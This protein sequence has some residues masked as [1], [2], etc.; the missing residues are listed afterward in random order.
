M[1]GRWPGLWGHLWVSAALQASQKT[2]HCAAEFLKRTKLVQPLKKQPPMNVDE[3]LL[4]QDKS[5]A[6]EHLRRALPYVESPQEPLREAGVRFMGMAGRCLRRQQQGLR[7]ICTA[8]Q[9]R[10]Q[11]AGASCCDQANQVDFPP[12]AQEGSS[13]PVS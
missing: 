12:R 5:Q 9:G 8:L 3:C 13:Q 7:L 2:L 11:R 10:R 6:A 1:W 4:A